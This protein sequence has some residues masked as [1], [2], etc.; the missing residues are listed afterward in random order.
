MTLV[1][2]SLS[3]DGMLSDGLERKRQEFLKLA[4]LRTDACAR[5]V[6]SCGYLGQRLPSSGRNRRTQSSV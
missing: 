1:Y 6:R 2:L 3:R 4:L 5:K